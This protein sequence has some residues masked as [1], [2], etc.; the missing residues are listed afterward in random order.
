MFCQRVYAFS[1]KS[2]RRDNNASHRL[3]NDAIRQR[4]RTI[5]KSSSTN[6]QL[7]PHATRIGFYQSQLKPA[8]TFQPEQW[9][10]NVYFKAI[11]TAIAVLQRRFSPNTHRNHRTIS[12]T[13]GK[14]QNPGTAAIITR[15]ASALAVVRYCNI[16]VFHKP[17]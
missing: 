13:S 15:I 8:V 14:L 12:S 7:V 3:M 11:F 6:F 16:A 5:T 9:P 2:T 1:S 17:I 10:C 4:P